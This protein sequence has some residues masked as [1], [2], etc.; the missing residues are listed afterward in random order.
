MKHLVIG[1]IVRIIALGIGKKNKFAF[2]AICL[3]TI[4]TKY[5]GFVSS[6]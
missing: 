3:Y 5:G 2:L 6:L 1:T 4:K